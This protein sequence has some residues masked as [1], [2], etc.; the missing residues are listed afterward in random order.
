MSV[1]NTSGRAPAHRTG[2]WAPPQS[3]GALA[4][5]SAK[6]HF[7]TLRLHV[8]RDGSLDHLLPVLIP[9]PTSRINTAEECPH[10]LLANKVTPRK[11][12][13]YT[14]SAQ[15]ALRTR[16]R[17]CHHC[18]APHLTRF[19]SGN[20]SICGATANRFSRLVTLSRATQGESTMSP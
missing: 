15:T 2:A 3:C 10:D 6:D 9:R 19:A 17:R 14:A 7:H 5:S 16:S 11:A 4:V 13:N 18:V 1:M 20:R 12:C 8:D